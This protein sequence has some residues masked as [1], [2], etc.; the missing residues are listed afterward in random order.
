MSDMYANDATAARLA[1]GTQLNGIFEI[2]QRIASGGMGE[3]YRGHAIETGDPVAIK[4]MRTDLA[5][6]TAALALFRKEAAT[7]HYLQHDAI[8]RYYIFSSDP[9]VRRYYLAMEFVDGRPLE[10]LLH[11]GPLIFEAVRLFQQRIAAGLHAA[12]QQGIVHR[13]VS[14]DNIL[15]PG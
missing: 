14:P 7:L 6:N 13:D 5:D 4:V 2:D 15:I 8:V 12:H 9:V 3:I 11:E 10:E 1:P